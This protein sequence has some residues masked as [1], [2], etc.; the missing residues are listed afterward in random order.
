MDSSASAKRNI[1]TMISALW[2]MFLSILFIASCALS[3]SNGNP[4]AQSVT[5]TATLP[6]TLPDPPPLPSSIEYIYPS[7]VLCKTDYDKSFS[8]DPFG[9]GIFVSLITDEI[10]V[11][12][13]GNR[14]YQ[15]LKDKIALYVDNELI[16]KDQL[17]IGDGLMDFGPYYLSW[18]IPLAPGSHRAKFQYTNDLNEIEEYSWEFLITEPAKRPKISI[19][20]P[21]PTPFSLFYT[22]PEPGEYMCKTSYDI[23][24][25]RESPSM[26]GISVTIKPDEVGIGRSNRKRTTFRRRTT[27][28][29]DGVLIPPESAYVKVNGGRDNP[30]SYDISWSP[31]LPPGLHEALL[32]VRGDDGTIYEYKWYFVLTHE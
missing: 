29:I 17:Q 31:D 9:G 32:Q 8:E 20:T 30:T 5:P 27:I 14:I 25:L 7:R 16:S 2:T 4:F 15:E 22:H 18:P 6:Q 26:R 21:A 24:L 1:G 12:P 11:T 13:K 3:N 10:G 28:Y 23:T 19:P